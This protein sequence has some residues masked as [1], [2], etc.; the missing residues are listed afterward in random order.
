[1]DCIIE[2]RTDESMVGID[3]RF[4]PRSYETSGLLRADC[5]VGAVSMRSSWKSN[6]LCSAMKYR[7]KIT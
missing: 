3:L 6:L 5:R 1:M 7:S 2:V 4:L